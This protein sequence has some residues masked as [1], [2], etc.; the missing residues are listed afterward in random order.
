MHH[1]GFYHDSLQFS[2]QFRADRNRFYGK[3]LFAWLSFNLKDA[4][5]L[6]SGHDHGSNLHVS[7]FM[8]SECIERTD[9]NLLPINMTKALYTI[10]YSLRMSAKAFVEF[11]KLFANKSSFALYFER[12]FGTDALE[13]ESRKKFKWFDKE[14]ELIVFKNKY[15]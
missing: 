12:S 3:Y 6:R 2:L 1:E 15:K 4:K 10:F 5:L 11:G 14:T 7:L 13:I 9:G 8:S